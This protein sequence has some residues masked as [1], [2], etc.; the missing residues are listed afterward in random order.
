M[1][2][3]TAVGVNVQ[4]VDERCLIGVVSVRRWSAETQQIG[5]VAVVVGVDGDGSV[6]N[7]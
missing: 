1:H 3:W 7:K 2:S 6:L 4:D 5:V